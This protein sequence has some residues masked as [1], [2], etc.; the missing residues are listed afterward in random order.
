M[1]KIENII[2]DLGGVLYNIDYH[3]TFSELSE[4]LNLPI[5]ENNWPEDFSKLVDDYNTGAIRT[6]TFIWNLQRMTQ[7]KV[8][9]PGKI[10]KAWN[11]MLIDWVP[12]IFE[13]MHALGEQYNLYLLSNI[14]DM[15]YQYID[16]EDVVPGGIEGF[17]TYF[18][19]T[20]YSHLINRKKPDVTTY[21]YVIDQYLLNK[22][23]T[24]FIDDF[25]INVNG[26]RA[27]GLKAIQHKGP[28]SIT[29]AIFSYLE[30]VC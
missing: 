3:K 4:V 23:K 7:G 11:A 27:C 29:K 25:E 16:D 1:T 26:A 21:Q 15:H 8:P 18:K 10:I 13:M 30:L 6:E 17:N 24:L 22:D 20:F 2:F 9:H 19:G 14:N 12:G 5:I 28:E